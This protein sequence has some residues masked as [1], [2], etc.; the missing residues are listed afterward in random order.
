M[1]KLDLSALKHAK[2]YSI[3]YI[4]CNELVNNE[5]L[6]NFRKNNNLTQVRLANILNVTK[7]TIEKWEQGANP[8]KGTS[9]ALLYLL[10][11]KPELIKEFYVEERNYVIDEVSEFEGVESVPLTFTMNNKVTYDINE[12]KDVQYNVQFASI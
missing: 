12:R 6:K 8:I 1:N 7:K 3:D 10:N 11:K 4:N 5:F 2:Y 9:A